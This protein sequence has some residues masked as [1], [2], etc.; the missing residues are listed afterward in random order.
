[1]HF[2]KLFIGCFSAAFLWQAVGYFLWTKIYHY[3]YPIP[4]NGY[5][6]FIVAL[7]AMFLSIW[8]IFPAHLRKDVAFRQRLK[9]ALIVVILNNLIFIPYAGMN[10]MIL[11]APRQYQWAVSIFL[12]L[13]R[14]F[15]V[16]ISLRWI[17][18]AVSGDLVSAEI[19]CN[20]AV[21][22]SHALTVAYIIGSVAT[23]ETS[24]AI[25]AI[26]FVINL[27]TCIKIILMK[28]GKSDDYVKQIRLLQELVINEMVDVVI[29]I[30]YLLTFIVAYYGPNADLIGNI[31]NGYWQYTQN[32]D[33]NHTIEYVFTFFLVDVCSLLISAS[34][35]WFS[36]RINFYKAY[37]EIMKEFGVTFM[38]QM[39]SS[40]NGVSFITLF[41]Q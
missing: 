18:K 10:K 13:I 30:T 40:L 15:N 33:V 2:Q 23:F 39:G 25:F 14:N 29:P 20:Q 11:L 21:C 4:M 34:L 36:C 35:L 8:F 7:P 32:D 5:V 26:D 27:Y 3:R 19:V 9:S 12:P 17:R 37:S 31:R 28:R 41:W 38:I 6:S 24:I 22:S 16:W 1:M